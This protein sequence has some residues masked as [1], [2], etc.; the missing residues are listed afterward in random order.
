VWLT[1]V[2]QFTAAFSL[3]AERLPVHTYNTADGL[4]L[5]GA[6]LQALQDSRGFL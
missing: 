6:I 3:R 4:P 2:L 5:Y 1:C